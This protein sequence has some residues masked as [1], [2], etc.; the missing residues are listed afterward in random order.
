VIEGVI[1]PLAR[2]AEIYA[3]R[4]TAANLL[5]AYVGHDAGERILAGQI[6]RGDTETIHAVIW[7]SDMRGFT[8]LADSISPERLIEVLNRYFDCQVPA[9]IAHGGEVLKFMGDGLLAIFPTRGD[10]GSA[11]GAALTAALDVEKRIAGSGRQGESD[12]GVVLR[13]GVALHLGEVLYGNV[14]G[15]NRLDFTCIGPGVNLAARIEA[16]TSKTGHPILASSDFARH[17]E[18]QLVPVGEFLLRG[19]SAAE[20]IFAVSEVTRSTDG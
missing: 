15:G 19:F 1:A 4:R 5:D 2:V 7:L 6:R 20:T 16:L 8:A 12:I 17:C 9:I 3:L 13:F 14:G 11:C 10:V 18:A